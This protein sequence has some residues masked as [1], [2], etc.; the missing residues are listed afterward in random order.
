[1]CAG[2][3]STLYTAGLLDLQ[4]KLPL[5]KCES[6]SFDNR[7]SSVLESKVGGDGRGTERKEEGEEKRREGGLGEMVRYF[8][9]QQNKGFNTNLRIHLMQV[10]S[11]PQN[12]IL[13]MW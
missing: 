7:Y 2:V 6:K 11:T 4:K 5:S 13:K 12:V 9:K 10:I 3:P 1:M 8:L